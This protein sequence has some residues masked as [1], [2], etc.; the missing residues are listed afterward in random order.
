MLS[1]QRS[2]H[3]QSVRPLLKYATPVWS[4]FT[5]ADITK[6]ESVQRSFTKRLPGLCHLAYTKRLD[7]LCTESL[8]LRHLCH[9]LSYVYKMLFSSVDLNFDDFFAWSSCSKT[10]G[11]S[12]KLFYIICAWVFVNT[13]SVKELSQFGI[14]WNA[15]L[16]IL[17]ILNASKCP[18]IL[19][20]TSW[21]P[22][23][24]FW[25][26]VAEGSSSSRLHLAL[27]TTVDVVNDARLSDCICIIRPHYMYRVQSVPAI[28]YPYDQHTAR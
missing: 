11:H 16:L 25:A 24:I 10:R 14:T 27:H 19:R 3:S 7:V 8:E 26:L 1:Y 21:E 6:I 13:F 18:R 22:S 2:R 20:S 15:T 23:H 5:V 9:D 12:Y 17:A 28:H 4:P